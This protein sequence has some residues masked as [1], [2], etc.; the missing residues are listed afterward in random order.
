MLEGCNAKTR[1]L[2]WLAVA[3]HTNPS[4]L[5]KRM[6]QSAVLP[7]LLRLSALEEVNDRG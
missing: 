2:K 5:S 3:L 6:M 1:F 7:R 4:S